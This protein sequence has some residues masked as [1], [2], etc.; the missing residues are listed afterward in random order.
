LRGK[1]PT[2]VVDLRK[3]DDTL[4]GFVGSGPT[5]L[6]L[7]PLDAGG[8][9]LR[10]M[11]SGALSHLEVRS[12]GIAGQLGRCQYNLRRYP[13]ELGAAYNGQR[14]CRVATSFEPATI[15]L[16]PTIAALEPI[17]RA[18]IITILLGR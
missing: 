13:S 3:E 15:T 16:A 6:H 1:G 12:D 18:A 9:E 8:F 5:E 14:I 11:F 17:D 4:R 2:G 7:E 10:G